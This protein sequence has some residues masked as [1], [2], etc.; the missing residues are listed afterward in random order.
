MSPEQAEMSALGVDTRS[1]IYSLGVLLYELLTGSTPLTHRRMKEVAYADILRMIKEEEPPKPSTRLSDSGES[2]ASISAQRH[3]EPAKLAKLMRGELDWIVMKCLEK[4]RNRR[5]ETPNGL[6][7]DVQRYLC[8]EAVQAVPPGFGYRFRKFARRNKGPVLATTL[9]LLALL[10]G[11]VGTAWQAVRATEE[12]NEKEKAYQE[13]AANERKAVEEAANALEQEGLA[14]RQRERAE[15]NFRLARE[16]VDRVLTRAAEEMAGKPHMEEIRRALLLDALEFYQGFLRQKGADPSVRH[17]TARAYLRVG[18]IREMLGQLEQA[19]A[20]LIEAIA[21]LRKLA[22]EFPAVPEYLAELADA[23]DTLQ[24]VL[25]DARLNRPKECLEPALEGLAVRKKLAANFPDR[26]HVRAE[27][28]SKLLSVGVAY[29][30]GGHGAKEGE[31]YIREGLAALEQIH[32]EAP[33]DPVVL[34]NLSRAHHW[35]G[36]SL[37]DSGRLK[38]AEAEWRRE[39]AIRA[40]MP[41]PEPFFD[42]MTKAYLADILRRTGRSGEALPLVNEVIAYR[43]KVLDDFP[44]DYQ[45]W[46]RLGIEY[47]LLGECL[48]AVGR[49]DETER[50]LRRSLEVTKKLVTDFRGAPATTTR[51]SLAWRHYNLGLF[52]QD[53]GKTAEAAALFRQAQRLFEECAAIL[54]EGPS[55]THAL[56]WFL[57]DCPAKQ[58]RDPKRA[59][60]LAKKALQMNP[61]SGRYWGSLAVAQARAGQWQEADESGRKSMELS[62][63]GDGH[64]W[65]VL[66][67]ARW[68]LGNKQEALKSYDQAVR[69]M[70]KNK[71]KDEEPRRFRTEAEE[72]TGF[73]KKAD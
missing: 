31:R 10:G 40:K 65:F 19:E 61:Q 60:E 33:D 43:E 15:N 12:R 11:T 51:Y 54:P 18:R 32:K 57:A 13:S 73:R 6:A 35:L 26:P 47:E 50:A 42:S 72:L 70:E 39:L 16:A 20:P 46:R 2:L 63:E 58:F 9:V 29:T 4:D 71:P 30:I 48:A 55:R 52:L 62:P 5:Y 59:V 27:V 3:T 14:R 56:A 67:M 49:T 68:H 44:N 22:A 37:R 69:W 45:T 21:L 64:L 36:Y 7:A 23:Y 38:E 1:D 53:A 17:E 34:L 66:A 28:A 41:R 24:M 25:S 8:G